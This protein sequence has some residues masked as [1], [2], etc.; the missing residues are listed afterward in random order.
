MPAVQPGMPRSD[1]PKASGYVCHQLADHVAL[2]A[3]FRSTTPL[4]A[5][6]VSAP[7]MSSGVAPGWCCAS[8]AAAPETSAVAIEVPLPRRYVAS[9]MPSVWVS[10][11]FEPGAR[12]DSTLV[13]GADTS[14]LE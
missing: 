11:I 12:Y 4:L 2:S 13:P 5:V 14:G 6:E 7:L 3:A 9:T 10:S 1:P 8:T